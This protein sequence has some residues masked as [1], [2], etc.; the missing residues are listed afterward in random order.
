M[1]G[2]RPKTASFCWTRRLA[3]LLKS[4]LQVNFEEREMIPKSGKSPADSRKSVGIHEFAAL[5]RS[6]LNGNFFFFFFFFNFCAFT[7][8]Q[9]SLNVRFSLTSP[10]PSLSLPRYLSGSEG[11]CDKAHLSGSGPGRPPH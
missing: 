5:A 10:P 8:I 11:P 6:S 9:L 1:W 3:H 2:V 7:Q 4:T